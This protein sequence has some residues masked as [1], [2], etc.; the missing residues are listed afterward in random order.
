[1]K[2]GVDDSSLE[3]ILD[4]IKK[5][6]GSSQNPKVFIYGSRVKGNFRKFSDIDLLLIAESYDLESLGNI[7]FE[8]IDLPYKIDFVLGSDL[9]ENYKK[10]IF[11][12][13]V[14]IF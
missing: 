5:N 13:M 2:F 12:H 6:V 8:D 10:E 3:I 14:Q 7:D 11:S 4:E 9:F 1:V